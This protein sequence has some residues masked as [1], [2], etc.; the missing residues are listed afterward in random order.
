MGGGGRTEGQVPLLR[1]LRDS[2]QLSV[3]SP[4][5]EQSP[6][7]A[8]CPLRRFAGPGVGSVSATAQPT[9]P[10]PTTAGDLAGASCRDARALRRVTPRSSPWS[11]AL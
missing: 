4:A 10:S 6:L 1:I 8:L 9:L 11:Q 2:A 7:C 3:P 5:G